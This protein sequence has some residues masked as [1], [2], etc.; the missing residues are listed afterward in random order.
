L[1]RTGEAFEGSTITVDAPQIDEHRVTFSWKVEP[2]A[3]STSEPRFTYNSLRINCRTIPIAFGGSLHSYACTA[4][5]ITQAMRII[6]PIV[7]LEGESEFWL[8]LMDS[9]IITLEAYRGPCSR[10]LH[11]ISRATQLCRSRPDGRPPDLRLVV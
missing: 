3:S 4:T 9:E 1:R 5:G 10:P 6:V 11:E 2:L 7:L 8:R